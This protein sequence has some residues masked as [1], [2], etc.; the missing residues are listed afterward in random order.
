M[1]YRSLIILSILFSACIQQKNI[2]YLQDPVLDKNIYSILDPPTNI[3]KPNDVLYIKVSSF[4]DI[5]FNFFS[6]QEDYTRTSYN[7]ELS[8]SLTGYQVNND[9]SIYF[10][11][12][13]EI[14]VEGLTL[15][16]LTDTLTNELDSYFNQPTVVVKYAFKKIVVLGEVNQPGHYT[17]TKDLIN[18]FEALGMAGDITIHGNKHEVMLLRNI[19]SKMVKTEIDLTDDDLVFREYYYLKPDDVLYIKPRRSITWNIISTPVSLIFS[20]IT[21]ALLILNFIK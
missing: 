1:H 15:E 11:I 7:N 2:E 14:F 9:G 3:I 8:L 20:T 21:T 6:E 5:A 10:P 16:E 4:D 13:G 17:Y 12:L 19:D 18:I